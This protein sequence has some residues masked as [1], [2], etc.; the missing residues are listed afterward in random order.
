MADRERIGERVRALRTKLG[1]TQAAL[2]ERGGL[3]RTQVV[4]LEAGR[5][6][7]STTAIRRRLAA[8]F[9]LSMENVDELLD[10]DTPIETLHARC[11][12]DES[13]A[14]TGGEAA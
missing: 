12:V 5:N 10:G 2:G 13:A 14:S 11:R 7:C 8:G 4:H 3:D 6:H 1:F 9:G